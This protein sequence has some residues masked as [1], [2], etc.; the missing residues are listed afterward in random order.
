MSF[1]ALRALLDAQAAA[2]RAG[3]PRAARKAVKRILRGE[4]TA[5]LSTGPH[6]YASTQIQAP[7][8]VAQ[9]VATLAD[10]ILPRHLYKREDE[11]HITC[12]YG[13]E[14]DDVEAVKNLVADFGPVRV[15][16]GKTATFPSTAASVG[17]TLYVEVDSPDLHRLNKLL[18][19]LPH[20]SSF[21]TYVPHLSVGTLFPGE[22][23]KYAGL[24]DLD[25]TTFTATH[26]TFS[27]RS[28]RRHDVWLCGTQ[29]D[30]ATSLFDPTL[31]PRGQ[32]ANAGQFAEKPAAPAGATAQPPAPQPAPAPA[33]PAGAAY[34]DRAAALAKVSELVHAP[35]NR[36]VPRRQR[37]EYERTL[38][39][40]VGRL[41]PAMAAAILPHLGEIELY[42]DVQDLT[43]SLFPG[44]EG[45]AGGAWSYFPGEPTGVLQIDGGAPG[46]PPAE[47]YAHELGHALDYQH[48]HSDTPEWQE[49]WKEEIARDDAPLSRYATWDAHEGLAEFGRLFGTGHQLEARMFPRC[50]ACFR[51]WGYV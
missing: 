25:G 23:Q 10:K 46:V 18:K 32:P 14:A 49:A 21:P 3:A 42:R 20:T 29:A 48:R 5:E 28:G 11:P 43:E 7:V 39:E 50:Y 44:E 24:A 45:L 38:H 31:H 40:V 2:T 35:H 9:K 8:E 1:P 6:S 4:V 27:E 41:T 26:L 17:E 47:I 22:S 13:I 19:K 34:P 51:K 30:L 37:E 36:H 12:L 33:A 15:T 16:L